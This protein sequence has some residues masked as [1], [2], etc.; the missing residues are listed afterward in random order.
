M[1]VATILFIIASTGCATY[2]HKQVADPADGKG[3][4]IDADGGE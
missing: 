3:G 4:F 1:I 2:P